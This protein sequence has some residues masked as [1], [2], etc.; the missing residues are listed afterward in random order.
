MR[1]VKCDMIVIITKEI[2]IEDTRKD[3]IDCLKRFI[4]NRFHDGIQMFDSHGWAGDYM[5]TIYDDDDIFI[6]YAPSWEY[7]EVFGLTDDEFNNLEAAYG[8]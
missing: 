4:Q 6:N 8:R 3:R 5:T 2:E 7:I 1:T